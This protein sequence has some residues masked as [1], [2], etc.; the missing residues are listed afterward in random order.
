MASG[1]WVEGA[2][3]L[4]SEAHLETKEGPRLNWSLGQFSFL[5]GVTWHSHCGNGS[6]EAREESHT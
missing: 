5:V 6:P 4:S 1:D 3:V 2:W